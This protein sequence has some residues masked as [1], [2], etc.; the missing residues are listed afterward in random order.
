MEYVVV[1]NDRDEAIGTMPIDDAH[2]DGTPHR[3][4]VTYVENASRQILVQIR[5]SG[6][7]DHSSA[8]HVRPG[9]SYLEAATREL[10][11]ELGIRDTP[12]IK[13]GHGVSREQQSESGSFK[14]HVFDV[15]RCVAEAADP[16]PDEVQ[17]V[18]WA[19]PEGT[20]EDMLRSA[21]IAIYAGGFRASLPIY[22]AWRDVSR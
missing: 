13:I 18:F 21:N 16:Q 2:R 1:V 4:A 6:A 5:M 10:A 3:I 19:D 15:F 14:T 8:G 11:E 22:L 12:L 9:E 20:M 7:R 17:G